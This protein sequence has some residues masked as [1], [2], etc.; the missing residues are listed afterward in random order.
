VPSKLGSG[1]PGMMDVALL[2]GV[3]H[4][5][6]SR[7][8]NMQSGVKATTRIRVQAAI[9]EFG[10]R[11]NR[12]ARTLATGRS[13]TL[14]VVML[15]STLYG[16]ASTLYGIEQAALSARYLVTVASARS[17]DRSAVQEAI[18]QLVDQ[19]V[20]GIVMIEG[21]LRTDVDVV[22]VDQTA[23]AKAATQHLLSCGHACPMPNPVQG[24]CSW[25]RSRKRAGQVP[26]LRFWHGTGLPGSA[27]GPVQW[28]TQA[29]LLRCL[30]ADK[31]GLRR[32]FG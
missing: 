28:A 27:L 17:K 22:T 31:A 23:G 3:S 16:P 6:V 13:Q 1:R 5:T 32:V 30:I 4:Q 29:A 21:D 10:Y 2:A 14:G 7:V 11:R 9:E 24:P 15:N 25:S 26:N 19:A 20:E 12:A 18:G 8:I